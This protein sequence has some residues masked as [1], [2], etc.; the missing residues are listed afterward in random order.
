MGK[1]GRSGR[2]VFRLLLFLSNFDFFIPS[3][4]LLLFSFG[5]SSVVVQS[6]LTVDISFIFLRFLAPIAS[7]F[8]LFA[9]LTP[10]RCTGVHVYSSSLLA[11]TLSNL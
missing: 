5:D 11:I 1:S 2:T 8:G 9:G 7:I 3:V 4:L 6:I 10:Y